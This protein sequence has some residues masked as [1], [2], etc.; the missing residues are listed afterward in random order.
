M[1]SLRSVSRI[2]TSPPQQDKRARSGSLRLHS[3]QTK[4][5]EQFGTN[6]GETPPGPGK[7]RPGSRFPPRP[8]FLPPRKATVVPAVL[9]TVEGA[10]KTGAHDRGRCLGAALRA[11]G[12]FRAARV[13]V[14]GAAAVTPARSGPASCLPGL[15]AGR[16]RSRR[17][18]MAQKFIE[19][20][21]RVDR[22]RYPLVP[23]P[24]CNRM[25]VIIPPPVSV[26]RY[27]RR[28]GIGAEARH[29]S[30]RSFLLPGQ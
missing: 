7:S 26:F 12:A 1:R 19:Y 25:S 24:C 28:N 18:P 11:A 22:I 5:G 6:W 21:P 15:S 4:G 17:S 13:L 10:S 23:K 30:W 9:I 14:E 29:C 3:A 27:D 2:L 20:K 16:H 8:L